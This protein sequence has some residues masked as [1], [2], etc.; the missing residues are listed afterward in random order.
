MKKEGSGLSIWPLFRSIMNCSYP[1]LKNYLLITLI[2][3][4][5]LVSC[6]K[7]KTKPII[8]VKPTL[9][10]LDSS[11]I[12]SYANDVQPILDAN[13]T[14]C[15]APTESVSYIPLHNYEA[16]KNQCPNP[17]LGVIKHEAGFSNMPLSQ[18]QLDNDIISLI[19]SWVDNGF[20]NN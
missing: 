2:L 5:S 15:H 7:D 16:V 1:S 19:E 11:Y 17:L 18:P 4:S 3:C 8:E 9:F 13:C 10:T 12:V 14:S 6:T 20:P